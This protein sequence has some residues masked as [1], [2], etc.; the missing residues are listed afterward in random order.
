M[1]LDLVHEVYLYI[2]HA[3]ALISVSNCLCLHDVPTNF[4]RLSTR[5][6]VILIVL[7]LL[8]IPGYVDSS[9]AR[10]VRPFMSIHS[11]CDTLY[12]CNEEHDAFLSVWLN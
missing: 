4:M 10:R 3:P 7:L 12:Q 9:V 2:E 8:L 11:G 6:V 5:H 1:F